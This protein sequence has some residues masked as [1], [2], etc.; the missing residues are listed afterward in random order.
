MEAWREHLKSY[1]FSGFGG[2]YFRPWGHFG[3]YWPPPWH[4]LFVFGFSGFNPCNFLSRLLHFGT[5]WC[6]FG[7][8]LASQ[9]HEICG[10]SIRKRRIQRI[11][12]FLT[13]LS[14]VPSKWYQIASKN[15]PKAPQ[16]LPK[17]T[18]RPPRR[19]Q[20]VTKGAPKSPKGAPR[21]PQRSP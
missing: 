7:L 10:F 9:T 14:K 21:V 1:F 15:D 16:R 3:P 5:L 20:S 13:F 2:L 4:F 8:H 6:H 11:Y 18:Q 17:E 12:T 19:A